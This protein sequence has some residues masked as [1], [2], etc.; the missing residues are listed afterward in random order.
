MSFSSNICASSHPPDMLIILI[1]FIGHGLG[2]RSNDVTA[3]GLADFVDLHRCPLNAS[4]TLRKIEKL[5]HV[6]M[7]L[8]TDAYSSFVFFD[9]SSANRLWY[10][11]AWGPH[12]PNV[13]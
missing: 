11:V 9:I 4:I 2:M 12:P 10:A 6:F 3:N 8:I 13:V 1:A 5:I 7:W